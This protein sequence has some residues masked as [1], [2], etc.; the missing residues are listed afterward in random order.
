MI[1]PGFACNGPTFEVT[2]EGDARKIG[3]PHGFG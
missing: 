1:N 2:A 3:L